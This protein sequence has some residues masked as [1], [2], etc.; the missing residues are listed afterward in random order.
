MPRKSENWREELAKDPRVVE[1]NATLQKKREA[2]ERDKYFVI[3]KAKIIGALE[4]A[5]ARQPQSIRDFFRHYR[6]PSPQKWVGIR[7]FLT[8]SRDTK[9]RR[10]LRRYVSFSARFGL[11]LNLREK[12]EHHF[13]EH[14]LVPWASIFHVILKQNRFYAVGRHDSE[15]R[16]VRFEAKGL[17]I[18]GV[19]QAQINEE[20]AR[21][22]QIEDKTHT[23][24]LSDIEQ[25]AYHSEGVTFV[26]HRAE[27][28]YLYLLVGEKTTNKV[29][30]KAARVVIA[31]QRDLFKREKAGRPPSTDSMKK[32][33]TA[34]QSGRPLKEEAANMA[35]ETAK[36]VAA[37]QVFLS[38]L[39]SK[40]K[41]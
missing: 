32:G 3:E 36:D 7:G 33:I 14:L 11:I 4:R 10:T 27:Q 28:P 25:F 17:E 30:R 18:P 34:R 29:L 12:Q 15:E 1:L 41:E 13:E 5:Y 16:L 19:L 31:F 24:V 35:G 8:N 40:L 2:L 37:K 22:L 9:L 38:R 26:L 39:G 21:F 23:S 6:N 20:V